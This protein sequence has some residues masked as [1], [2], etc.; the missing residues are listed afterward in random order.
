[1]K[2]VEWERTVQSRLP[3][4][5]EGDALWD[6]IERRTWGKLYQSVVA[7]A[8]TKAEQ[9]MVEETLGREDA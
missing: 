8:L 3:K 1:M 9:T 7:I 4:S 2:V 6:K 5:P